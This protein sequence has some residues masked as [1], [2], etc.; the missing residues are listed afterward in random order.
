ML[1][2]EKRPRTRATGAPLRPPRGSPPWLLLVHQLPP[3]PSN[4]RVRTWRRLQQ[5]GAVAVKN[6]VY[7]L[8]NAAQG[9]ED[10]EWIRSEIAALGGQ[11]SV[12]AAASAAELN[13]DEI[14]RL[15]REARRADYDRLR[16]EAEKA[17]RPLTGRALTPAR[18][19]RLQRAARALREQ[20]ERTEAIDFFEAPGRA[21]AAAA[22]GRLDERIGERTSPAARSDAAARPLDRSD[23]RRR[24]WVTRPRSGVDRMASAWLIRR[25]I[26]AK[27][28]FAFAA[29]ADGLPPAQVPFDMFGVEFG[30]HGDS[31]TFETLVDRFAIRDP[32]AARIAQIVHDLDLKTDR[33]ALP[34]GAGLG[35]AIEGLQ[36][37]YPNDTELLER[38]II[39]F[40]AV[41]RAFGARANIAAATKTRRRA[42]GR[43]RR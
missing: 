40:E 10:F 43:R 15:F 7:V 12:F 5:V 26:D 4:I 11:A 25:F 27:A 14:T 39:V 2:D 28:R 29:S 17:A 9:R 21:S 23:Y 8:P 18:R 1:H 20:L 24:V 13:D 33:Y 19:L 34:E 41:Y 42:S 6:S 36:H 35:V 32:A 30:H 37:V 22:I 16:T 3:R 38:G 31:C